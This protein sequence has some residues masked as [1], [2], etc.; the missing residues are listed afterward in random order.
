M[1]VTSESGNDYSV[2]FNKQDNSKV[3][4]MIKQNYCMTLVKQWIKLSLIVIRIIHWHKT[5][6]TDRKT[7]LIIVKLSKG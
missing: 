4:G 1:I 3:I 5:K 7:S 6:K 2:N